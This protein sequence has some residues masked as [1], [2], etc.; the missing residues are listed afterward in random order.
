MNDKRRYSSLSIHSFLSLI[1]RRIG[2]CCLCIVA[3]DLVWS[4]A[5]KLRLRQKIIVVALRRVA[6]IVV[7]ITVVPS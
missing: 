1:L 7:V 5:L 4:I 6:L 3:F 2:K